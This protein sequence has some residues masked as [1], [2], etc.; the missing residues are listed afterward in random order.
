MSRLYLVKHEGC[1]CM[2]KKKKKKKKEEE[3]K[4]ELHM[5]DMCM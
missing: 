5:R 1:T 4:T 2:T 3:K